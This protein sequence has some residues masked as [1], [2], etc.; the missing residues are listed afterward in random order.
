VP[1]HVIRQRFGAQI[2][3]EVV[4]DVVQSSYSEAITRENLRPAG[5]P[6][7]EP[8][9]TESGEDLAFTAVF[10]VFPEFTLA[11]MDQLSVEVPEAEITDADIDQ[12]VGQLQAQRCSWRSVERPAAE[13]DRL[14]LDF[15]GRLDDQPIDGGKAQNFEVIIGGG[16]MLADFEAGLIGVAGGGEKSF[17]VHFPVDYHEEMLRDRNVVFHVRVSEVT[18]RVLPALDSDFARACGVESGDPME[19]RQRIRDNLE[20]EASARAE[21]DTRRQIMEQLLDHNPVE[22][23]SVL[24]E[25]EAATLHNEGMRNLGVSDV[26]EALS[27]DA[28]RGAAERRVR[29]GLIMGGVIRDQG[30]KIEQAEVDKRL[31]DLC[32]GY[33]R[34][35][36]AR[37]L[38][39]QSPGL[40]ARIEN[41]I[42]HEQTMNW[43]A[44]R[45]QTHPK[46]VTLSQLL[47]A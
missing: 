23:P 12:A 15:D 14:V 9:N 44:A 28:Y 4:A 17:P 3:K 19:L 20:R 47:G 24:V 35:D 37:K 11:G 10:E 36:E 38:Y 30:L 21:A 5:G 25:R 33:D 27:V 43:L 18:E 26:S 46:K 2:R 34:P 31:D 42:L 6:A 29:L 8:E 39:L 40:M 1:A 16:R 32:R 13:G 41:S 7:F 22:L 45:A